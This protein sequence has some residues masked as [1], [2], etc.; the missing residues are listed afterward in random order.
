MN[1]LFASS[2][3]LLTSVTL[4]IYH[5]IYHKNETKNLLVEN[6]ALISFFI[7][8]TILFYTGIWTKITNDIQLHLKCAILLF[9]GSVSVFIDGKF[10]R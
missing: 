5:A 8:F 3:L 10:R 9:S 2:L 7:I 1:T 6:R 4:L